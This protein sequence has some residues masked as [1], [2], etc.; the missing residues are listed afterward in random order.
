MM[1]DHRYSHDGFG[2]RSHVIFALS[3]MQ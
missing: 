2:V 3:V 1:Y